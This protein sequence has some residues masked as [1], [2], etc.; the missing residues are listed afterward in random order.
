VLI[1]LFKK[2]GDPET[3]ATELQGLYA[4]RQ[5]LSGEGTIFD[6]IRA[7]EYVF[8]FRL[9]VG[10]AYT[11]DDFLV[12]FHD[13][14]KVRCWNEG[15]IEFEGWLTPSEGN[16]SFRDHPYELELVA[17]DGLGFLKTDGISR[18][19][20][21]PFD[22]ENTLIEYVAGALAK[23]RLTLNI[24][25]YCQI[26]EASTGDRNTDPTA[27][28]FK[29]IQLDYRTYQEDS[30]EMMSCYEALEKTLAEGFT[31]Y[32]WLGRWVI[33]RCGDLQAGPGPRLWY[34]EYTAEGVYESNEQEGFDAG[35]VA[36][37]QVIHPRDGD[38]GVSTMYA[39]KFA[40]YTYKY[41]SWP[42]LPKN[43]KFERGTLLD[44]GPYIDEED[45]DSDGN[46]TEIIGSYKKYSI[47]DWDQGIV[48]L[49]DLPHPAM[50]PTTNKFYRQSIYNE[51][52][53]EI[54]RRIIGESFENSIGSGSGNAFWLRSDGIPV[55]KGGRIEYGISKRFDNDF[56]SGGTTFTIPSVVYLV[57]ADGSSAYFLD[58]NVSGTSSPKALWRKAVNLAGQL[59]MDY[60]PDQD[61]RDWNTLTVASNPLPVDG[62]IYIAI[63][64]NGPVGNTGPR[65]HFK[66]I[67][68]TYHPYVAGGYIPVKGDSWNTAQNP[69]YKDSVNEEVFLSDSP[70][71]IFKGALL[72][73]DGLTPT[74][75]TWYRLNVNEQREFKE[76]ANLARYN[77]AYR[78]M[79]RIQGTF[80]G[81][82]YRPINSRLEIEPLGFHR[83]FVFLDDPALAG[84]YFALVTPLT[85]D[86]SAGMI[87][88][89]FVEIFDVN[90]Q[91]G[92]VEGDTHEF[93]YIFK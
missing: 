37:Q 56:S 4:R 30:G 70:E 62:T 17:T 39:V 49:F 9:P 76:L 86:Y 89:T 87:K 67:N 92:F 16:S 90:T 54:D 40:K 43:I 38:Q 81:T 18:F 85:I 74:T 91:D 6:T 79:K 41:V 27:D 19:D 55:K 13:E 61:T 64:A 7:S 88:A 58:N 52:G 8:G 15:N 73:A 45:F 35:Q 10:S 93:K 69:D 42:E 23:T 5:F 75:R 77:A 48:D 34:S 46:T 33:L 50:A 12:S 14:W 24:R 78:R 11:Y 2:D 32:Q 31:I 66:D 68:I 22:D 53:V 84:K 83:H 20:A 59:I 47:D 57:A 63:P 65:Q 44:E 80:G 21:T 29:S 3:I 28:M 26:F 71:K 1:E 60:A 51:F 82:T 25:T 72:Q 36:K